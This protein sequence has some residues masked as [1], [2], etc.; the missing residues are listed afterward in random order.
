MN[1]NSQPNT[2]SEVKNPLAAIFGLG[3]ASKE[4]SSH[5]VT[6]PTPVATSAFVGLLA[7]KLVKKKPSS[8]KGIHR[9]SIS[10]N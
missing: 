7:S 3:A 4:A 1:G 9:E 8:P 6:S 5:E 2:G 10:M